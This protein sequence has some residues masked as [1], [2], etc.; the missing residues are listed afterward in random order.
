ML[1]GVSHSGEKI[2]MSENDWKNDDFLAFGPSGDDNANTDDGGRDADADAAPTKKQKRP[3]PTGSSSG[4]FGP[5]RTTTA[6]ADLPPWMDK[7]L[8]WQQNLRNNR[9]PAPLVSLHNEI[10]EFAKLME[11]RQDEIRQ[12]EELVRKVTRLAEQTFGGR[13]RC[14]VKVF[15]SQATGLFLPSSDIDLVLLIIPEEN[16]KAA[17]GASGNNGKEGGGAAAGTSSKQ[18][19]AESQKEREKREMEEWDATTASSSS[20]S[21][22]VVL[23]EALRKHWI[24]DLSY[25]EIIENTRI[26]I[27]KFTHAPTN[28]SVDIC[29]N[30]ET[31]TKAAELVRRFGDAMPPLRPLTFVL[32]YFMAA[33]GLNEPYTG[34]VGSFLLQMMIVSFLQHREREEFH[35]SGSESIL[36]L[37]ALLLEF[38][39]LYGIDFNYVTTGISIRNDGSY[40]PKGAKNRR[41]NYWQPARPF[42]LALENPFETDMDVGKS[43]FRIQLVQRSFEVAFRILMSHVS[44]PALPPKA[45]SILASILLPTDEM[46]TRAVHQSGA[47]KSDSSGYRNKKDEVEVIGSSGSSDMDTSSSSGAGDE[48]KYKKQRK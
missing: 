2:G 36:N 32:K 29:L 25:L 8:S 20:R 40:F 17:A 22:L 19:D 23:G 16:N 3:A 37:G 30:Q 45:G 10:V 5:N 31:G 43:S 21:P 27:V 26:P 33:R 35:A 34:G 14:T 44:E 11:P 18:D 42:S 46:R 1:L 41:E 39:E 48:P 24:D 38:F 13:E 28:L 47:S 6:N 12:R 9:R 15:G 4:S 7:R